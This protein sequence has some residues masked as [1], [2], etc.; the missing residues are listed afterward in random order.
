MGDLI[1]SGAFKSLDVQ[2]TIINEAGASIY[3]CSE[4][5]RQ[6]FPDL[7]P[8]VISA[9]AKLLFK[10]TSVVISSVYIYL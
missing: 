4:E 5:A 10:K 1:E 3:S 2:Y 8:N 6:E 7:D 9:G